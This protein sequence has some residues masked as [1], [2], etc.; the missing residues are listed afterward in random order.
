MRSY[1]AVAGGIDV[2]PVLGSRSTDTLSGLGPAAVAP[3]DV[4]PIGAWAGAT[5]VPDGAGVTGDVIGGVADAMR[6]VTWRPGLSGG[7]RCPRCPA[8]ATTGSPAARSTL[9]AAAYR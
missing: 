6:T 5:V 4:L 1:L 7:T 2:P 9:L 8:R 3:G